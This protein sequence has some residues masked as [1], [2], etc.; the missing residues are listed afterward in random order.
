MALAAIL[1]GEGAQR[2]AVM[3]EIYRAMCPTY[4]EPLFQPIHLEIDV[5]ERTAVLRISGLLESAVEPIRNPVTGAAHRARIDLPFGREFR[6]AEVA[7]GRTRATGV[8]PLAFEKTH[9]HLVRN[10]LSSAGVAK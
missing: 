10:R 3:L 7:S 9:A 4:H 5:E 8:I 6:L 2:G 1:Q